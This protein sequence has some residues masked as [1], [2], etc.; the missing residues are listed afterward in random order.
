MH[1]YS[2]IGSSTCLHRSCNPT[3]TIN[4]TW[5][6]ATPRSNLA[7]LFIIL[8]LGLSKRF[9]I[10]HFISQGV[11]DPPWHG[12]WCIDGSQSIDRRHS[13]FV[14]WTWGCFS[15]LSSAIPFSWKVVLVLFAFCSSHF[16]F[17]FLLL[18]HFLSHC[19]CVFIFLS[20]TSS[21]TGRQVAVHVCTE[22]PSYGCMHRLSTLVVS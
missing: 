19:I 10:D 2:T 22:E 20:Q 8:F 6:W 7:S 9:G 21:E 15:L 13:C 4:L 11:P 1:S 14:H 5:T 17:S 18:F 3:I 12:S 16:A